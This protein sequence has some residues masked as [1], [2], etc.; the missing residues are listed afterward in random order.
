MGVE[1]ADLYGEAILKAPSGD[2]SGKE[3]QADR[4]APRIS[5][6]QHLD[7]GDL[8]EHRRELEERLAALKVPV[9]KEEFFAGKDPFRDYEAYLETTDELL[10]TLMVLERT[11]GRVK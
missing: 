2:K 11:A 3:R 4:L 6:L 10:A 1:V 9:T 8:S 7:L 5:R